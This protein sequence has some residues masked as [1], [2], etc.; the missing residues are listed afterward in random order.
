M[1]STAG[2]RFPTITFAITAFMAFSIS[3]FVLLTLEYATTVPGMPVATEP[4]FLS[5]RYALK[6]AFIEAAGKLLPPF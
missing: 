3:R 4:L 5:M 1:R 2:P 6:W